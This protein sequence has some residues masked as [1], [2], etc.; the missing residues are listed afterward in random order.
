MRRH[1][2]LQRTHE[3]LEDWASWHALHP[4]GLSLLGNMTSDLTKVRTGAQARCLV[5]LDLPP[6]QISR[7]DQAL[8]DPETPAIHR[9]VVTAYYLGTASERRTISRSKH[10]HALEYFAGWLVV[11]KSASGD[12]G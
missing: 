10:A 3:A 1:P 7:V 4:H 9:E 5:P 2:Y 8:S 6:R 11:K 12:A